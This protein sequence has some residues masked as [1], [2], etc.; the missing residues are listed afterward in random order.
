MLEIIP[1]PAFKDNYIW[2]LRRGSYAVVVDPGAAAPVIN[3]LNKLDLTLDGILITHHHADHIDGV[4]ELLKR[5][6]VQVYAP[7]KEHYDF[8]H[9]A[10]EEGSIISLDTLGL[11]LTV[12]EVPG[13]TLGHV[14]YYG[15]NYL[16]CG[17]T[18]FGA[19]CGRLFEGTP[20]Q[21]YNSLQRLAKLPTDTAVYCTHE[22]TE[23]NLKFAWELDAHNSALSQRIQQA[24]ITRHA[25]KPT[26]PSTI[27][28]ELATNPFLRCHMP[29]IQMASGIKNTDPIEVFSAIRELRN[30]F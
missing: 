12:L 23:H 19:G 6:P 7:K 4:A 8:N 1:I 22:Y 29:A 30:H 17:D 5:W 28:L 18:L 11:V 2:L 24:S 9:Q 10:V 20:R 15:A 16:F 21:M 25:S 26:L 14:A 3:T 13:H 27:A